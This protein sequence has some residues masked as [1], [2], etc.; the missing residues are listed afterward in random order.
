VAYPVRVRIDYRE[1]RSR[2]TTA[3]RFPLA[4]PHLVAAAVVGIAAAIAVPVAWCAI[5]VTGRCPR[6]ISRFLQ[7]AIRYVAR[8]G[9]YWMLV[10]DPFPPFRLRP[11]GHDDPVEVAVD[12]PERHARLSVVARLPLAVPAWLVTYFLGLFALMMA[13]AAWWVI[14]VT[15]RLPR[16]MFEVMELPHRYQAR[17]AAYT[18]LLVD[19]YPWFR[20][21]GGSAPSGWGAQPGIQRIS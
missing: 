3:L 15:G 1:P 6:P 10:T 9:C 19:E 16:S 4:V 18:C 11:A 7:G 8:V 20:E 13:F 14:L 17:V 12:E 5:L 2:L 21:E